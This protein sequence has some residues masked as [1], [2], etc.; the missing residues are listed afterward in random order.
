MGLRAGTQQGH[1]PVPGLGEPGVQM[2]K[3]HAQVLLAGPSGANGVKHLPVRGEGGSRLGDGPHPLED[4][5]LGTSHQ[6]RAGPPL[7]H[8]DLVVPAA[9]Q[10]AGAL[11]G[12]E[13]P[14]IQPWRVHAGLD[15]EHR[16]GIALARVHGCDQGSDRRATVGRLLDDLGSLGTPLV[17]GLDN[18]QHSLGRHKA[19]QP[20]KGNGQA[21]LMTG[22]QND[23]PRVLVHGPR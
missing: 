6:H 2:M 1:G 5:R 7:Q 10:A 22:G 14:A 15:D 17:A 18:G 12:D 11:Q 4:Q 20:I 21:G 8:Q 3:G 23:S 19:P 9:R 16:E 13:P